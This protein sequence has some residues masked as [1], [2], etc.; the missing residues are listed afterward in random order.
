M[1]AN[2]SGPPKKKSHMISLF[3]GDPARV[4]LHPSHFHLYPVHAASK[5]AASLEVLLNSCRYGP[6]KS[7]PRQVYIVV[8]KAAFDIRCF[9]VLL[10]VFK[11]KLNSD[12]STVLLRPLLPALACILTTGCRDWL[13]FLPG[14]VQKLISKQME[15]TSSVW[16]LF[17]MP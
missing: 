1:Q 16:T 15:A 9:A 3:P 17:S 6:W 7:K 13:V 4:P 2:C 11:L 5:H 14:Q 8:P 12:A 10:L